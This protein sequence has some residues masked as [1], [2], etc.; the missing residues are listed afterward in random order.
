MSKQVAVEQVVAAPPERVW[1]LISDVT[2]MGDWSPEA[3]GGTWVKGASRPAVGAKFKGRNKHGKRSWST[4]CTVT[5]AE[6]GRC[7]GFDVDAGPLGVA[8]WSYTIDPNPDGASC[9]VTETWTD[10]RGMLITKLG[11][12]LTGVSD[13]ATHNRSTM[14]QTLAALAKAAEA[15]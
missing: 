15:S 9:T 6:P 4:S 8:N 13:R 5:D 2:R 11:G 1:D 10:R 3:I 14:E 12:V 7:F